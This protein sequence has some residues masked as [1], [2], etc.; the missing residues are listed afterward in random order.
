MFGVLVTTSYLHQQ[1]YEEFKSDGHPIVV[2]SARD[3]VDI[4]KANGYG[5][6]TA[7]R[8]WL[9]HEFPQ[10]TV[11]SGGQDSDIALTA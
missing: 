6:A 2:I 8:D 11:R 7:V 3:V 1:A 10:S 9:Q 4:L 5:D